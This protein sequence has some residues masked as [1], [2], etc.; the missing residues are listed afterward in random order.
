MI[1]LPTLIFCEF[2]SHFGSNHFGSSPPRLEPRA[3]IFVQAGEWCMLPN[4]LVSYIVVEAAQ[5]LPMRSDVVLEREL[6]FYEAVFFYLMFNR[7]GF[8]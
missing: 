1:T 5:P 8:L 6:N 3:A 4:L 7:K 2:R